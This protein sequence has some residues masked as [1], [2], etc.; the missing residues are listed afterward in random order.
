[1]SERMIIDA[2]PVRNNILLGIMETKTGNVVVDAMIQSA[3]RACIEELD[4]APVVEVPEWRRASD[5]PPTHN[6]T[7]HDGDEVYSGETS[8]KVWAYCADGTQHDAHY[9]IHD[10]NGQWF[11]EGK[12]DKF[13]EHGNVTHWMYYPAAP[14]NLKGRKSSLGSLYTRY[15]C[16]CAGPQKKNK[17]RKLTGAGGDRNAQK[18]YQRKKDY[19]W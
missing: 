6:E 2:L 9:E 16:D 17:H 18:L 3:F 15:F 11:V 14:H 10:G 8:M 1:M 12:D 19:L 4:G 7:W 5:P 13:S